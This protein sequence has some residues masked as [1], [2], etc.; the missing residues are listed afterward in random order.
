MA[1]SG[2]FPNGNPRPDFAAHLDPGI[3]GLIGRDPRRMTIAELAA[4]RS[5]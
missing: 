3:D 4:A 2:L 1:R 5:H